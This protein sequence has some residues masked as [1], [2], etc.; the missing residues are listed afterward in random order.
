M[1]PAISIHGNVYPPRNA[2]E[3]SLSVKVPYKLTR[4]LKG[5]THLTLWDTRCFAFAGLTQEKGTS[6]RGPGSTAPFGP[7]LV[8]HP[9]SVK[10]RDVGQ[11]RHHPIP[12]CSGL[13]FT[14]N[15]RGQTHPSVF[16]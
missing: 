2:Q 9:G 15:V 10:P 14:W 6:A 16:P 3:L 4:N 1:T 8:N 12:L 11:E 5:R 13:E 7:V